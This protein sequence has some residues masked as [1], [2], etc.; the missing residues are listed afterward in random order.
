MGTEKL[1]NYIKRYKITVPRTVE[2]QL[3]SCAE[4][5]VEVL[6]TK[7]NQHMVSEEA[8]DLLNK[9]LVYD[10][11]ERITPIEAMEHPYFAPLKGGGEGKK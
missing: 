5:G 4:K 2:K 8:L 6:I 1:Y 7:K 3:K 9:M 10:K 11:N